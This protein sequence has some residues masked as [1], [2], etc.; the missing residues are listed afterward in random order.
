VTREAFSEAAEVNRTVREY[1]EELAAQNPTPEAPEA[2]SQHASDKLMAMLPEKLSTTDPD[3]TWS[4]KY[5]PAVWA[6][7]DNYLID[8]ESCIVLPVSGRPPQREP[9]LYTHLFVLVEPSRNLVLQTAT[10]SHRSRHLHLGCRPAS[11]NPSLYPAVCQIGPAFPLEIW[12]TAMRS[13]ACV[14]LCIG[15]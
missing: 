8:N 9:A 11:Q 6:Y 14:A 10:R 13:S 5:G 3:A 4:G 15:P 2:V 1:L 7:Y 12:Q